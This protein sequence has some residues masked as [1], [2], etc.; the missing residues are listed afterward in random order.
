MLWESKIFWA[1]QEGACFASELT[2]ELG[3]KE[4]GGQNDLK[5]IDYS[6][7]SH[8]VLVGNLRKAQRCH[9]AE[10]RSVS[11]RLH[12]KGAQMTCGP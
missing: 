11:P 6:L 10:V 4:P 2:L 7:S 9:Q 8:L 1:T 3:Q 5:N 12:G